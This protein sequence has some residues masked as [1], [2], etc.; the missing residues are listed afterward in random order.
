[1]SKQSGATAS[2]P[3]RHNLT[4]H[5]RVSRV[6]RSWLTWHYTLTPCRSF[7]PPRDPMHFEPSFP[8]LHPMTWRVVGGRPW[9]GALHLP[10]TDKLHGRK[11]ELMVGRCR[12]TQ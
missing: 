5:H 1:M 7:C 12:L 3:R 10:Q 9:D 4:R 2:V 8:E 11:L 6:T